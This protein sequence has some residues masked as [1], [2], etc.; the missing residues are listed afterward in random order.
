M[1]LTAFGITR[2]RLTILVMVLLLLQGALLFAAF[3]KR[4]DPSII[5]RTVV[6]VVQNPGLDIHQTE[7]Q[8]AKPLEEEA[9]GVAGVTKVRTLVSAGRAVLN[10]DVG[11]GVA[12][13]DLPQL[14]AEIRDTMLDAKGLMPTN[15]QGPI[16]N[17]SFGAVAIAT[18]AVTGPGFSYAEL[19]DIAEGLSDRIYGVD[20]V[21]AVSAYGVQDERIWLDVDQRRL[22]ATG[23]TLQ[24]AIGDIQSQNVSL[25]AGS[26]QAGGTRIDMSASG[27][28]TSVE[29]IGET[30]TTA[31]ND[32][33]VRVKDLFNIRR[34]YV[35]PVEKPVYFNEAA[36]VLL[37]VEMAAGYNVVAVGTAVKAVVEAAQNEAPW[38]VYYDFPTFQADV[39]QATVADAL[40]NVAQTIIVVLLVL[41][42]F[43]GLRGA[44]TVAT[45]VPFTVCVA[46]IGMGFLGIELQQVSIAAVVISLG[47]L[48]DNG[49]VIVEDMERRVGLGQ[50]RHEAAI[51]AGKQYSVPLMIAS[52]TTV[53]AFMPLFLLEGSEGEFGFSLGAVV[54]L[55]LGGSWF[56]AMYLLP[57]LATLMLKQPDDKPAKPSFFDSIVQLY[58]R[59]VSL[60]LKVPV[61]TV[62]LTLA[63]VAVGGM[64]M[65][66]VKSQLFPFS[67]RAQFLVYLDH[68]KGTDIATTNA[69]ARELDAWLNDD[70]INP[71]IT[72][73]A[74]FVADGGPRFVLSLAP[75][76]AAPESAFF[77][78][79]A[80]DY[81][82]SLNAIE[83]IRSYARNEIYDADVRIRRLTMG[84][85]EP[86]VEISIKGPDHDVLLATARQLQ[87]SFAQ[88]P[89]IEQ[90]RNDWGNKRL[91]VQIA[92]AQDQARDYGVTSS[93]VSE[94]LEAFFDGST[95]SYLVDGDETIPIVGRAAEPFRDTIEDI[96]S[97]GV[98][99]AGHLVG[100][101]QF[102]MPLPSLE[103]ATIRREDLMPTITITATSRTL[104]AY[105][106]FDYIQPEIAALDLPAGH[107]V[108]IGGEVEKSAEI[109]QKLG[110]GLLPA[111]TAIFAAL[112]FQFNSFRRVAIT[113]L[114]I[115]LV[116]FGAPILLLLFD[117]PLSFFGLLGLI[118]LAGIIINNAIVLIDQIDIERETKTLDQSI[119][120]AA[121]KRFRPI[122]LT[123]LTTVIGLMPMAISGGALWEPMATLMIGGLGFAAILAL[124]Y[125]PA[126]Y[127]LFFWRQRT[128]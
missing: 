51:A 10:I 26:L 6:A 83:R 55:M 30:L 115:P 29:D 13:A 68:Q 80:V 24:R 36:A 65:G 67:E 126:L 61:V 66:Q 1:G 25:P 69:R 63:I 101:D 32:G 79:N 106:L 71:D 127:K 19:S 87:R 85:S 77:I 76:D 81:P 120:D 110:S 100:L 122:L 54:G 60:A 90:N 15:T 98:N 105:E 118:S 119:I 57:Y 72:D 59:L 47:L 108:E 33:L 103:F 82:S 128:G 112:M 93:S 20:G 104:D 84:G 22:A 96:L 40:M 92:I 62:A 31:G 48:V 86:L 43:I 18:V 5:I 3:P 74:L 42:V 11:D 28:F 125:V 64:L 94:T 35:D 50:T 7:R 38:G 121:T 27:L 78:V 56:A 17:T 2:S 73:T 95:I 49:L 124:L 111:L 88:A 44:L 34:G 109:G 14:F 89:G 116:I 107:S 21:S 16:V 99:G 114:S 58:G 41:L 45:I 39:V 70:E 117:R 113:L 91:A 123:S 102:S 37:S 46:I 12:E 8:L 9:R 53:S 4:E 23:A 97:A 52:I 75:A